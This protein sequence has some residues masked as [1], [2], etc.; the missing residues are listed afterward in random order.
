MKRVILA[1]MLLILISDSS[2]AEDAGPL[3]RALFNNMAISYY[4]RKAFGIAHYQ[5]ARTG[6]VGVLSPLVG[7]NKAV[8]YVDEMDRKFRNDPRAENPTTQLAKCL[9][10]K[11]DAMHQIE[12]EQA[13]LTQ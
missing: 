13:K 2:R 3:T 6:A 10:L 1:M 8:G 9:E 7:H 11:N 12:V 5:A 4:C